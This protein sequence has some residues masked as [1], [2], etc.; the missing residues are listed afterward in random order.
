MS[1]PS[2]A[3]HNQVIAY[4]AIQAKMPRRESFINKASSALIDESIQKKE[5][6]MFLPTYLMETHMQDV[7]YE[8]ALY[9]I[10][11]MGVLTDGRRINVIL[12]DIQPYFEVQ[13]PDDRESQ[14]AAINKIN[15]LLEDEPPVK[16][17]VVNAK[18]FRYYRKTKAK[19]LRLYYTKTKSRCAAIRLVRDNGFTTTT[20]DTAS[21]YRVV[22]R[23][24]LTTFSSWA[25][26]EDYAKVDNS[27][28]LKGTTY[29]VSIQNYKAFTD[30]LTGDLLKDK[31]LSV[32]WD[33]ETWSKDGDV[34][35]P[36]N[37]N[38]N[39]FC[40]SMTFQWVNEN[41]P[42]YKV[43]LCDYPANAKQ[44]YA[45][46]V[47]GKEENIIRGFADIFELMRPE[48]IFGFN[49]SDYDWN[50]LIKRAAQYKGVLSYIATKLDSTIPY[51]PYTDD[52]VFKWSF[53]KEH[54]KVEADTY[55]D[56]FALMVPGYIPVDVRTIF[57]RL[58]PTAEQSSLKWFLAKNKLGGKEDMPY[59]EMFKIYRE[60][61]DF[62]TVHSD[63]TEKVLAGK[64]TDLPTDKW[65]AKELEI[66]N[67]LKKKLMDINYYCVIDAQRCHDLVKIRSVVMDHREVSNLAYC[68]V[69]DAFFRANGM[70]V[71]NLTIAIG[72]GK[73]FGMRFSNIAN[74]GAEEGKYPGAFVLPP[75]KGLKITKLSV[76]ERIKKGE[77]TK[78]MPAPACQEW[79]GTQQE[80]IN[81]YHNI[82]NKYG[83]IGTTELVASV[84]ADLGEKLP[85]KF[86]DFW[87]ETIGRPITGLDFSSLYPSLIRAYNFSPEFCIL[88]KKQAQ[89]VAETGQR[90][91]KVDFDFHGKRKVAYFI[92]HNNKYNP[93]EPGFQFGVYPYILD[94]LFKKRAVLKKAMKKF[95]HRKEEIEAM[96]MEEQNAV[97]AEYEDVVF[98]NNYLN[99]K[100]NAL[101]V[102]MNTFYGEAGNRRSPFFVMEVAGGITS[103]GQKNIKFAYAFVK[104]KGCGV[105]YGDSV[106]SYTPILVKINGEETYCEIK[107]LVNDDAYSDYNNGKEIAIL[108]DV[109]VW[110]DAGWSNIKHII[111]HKTDKQMFRIMTHGAVI[112]VTEDH[113]LLDENAVAIKPGVSLGQK[114]L[115]KELPQFAGNISINKE[116]AWVIGLFV[117]EGSCGSYNCKSGN[118]SSWGLVNQDLNLLNK[119][120]Q[121]LEIA[122][123]A[124]TWKILNCMASSAVHK[125][126]PCSNLVKNK[127]I[128][129]V[130]EWRSMCYYE[131]SKIVPN[132]IFSS[133]KEI[134]LEFF[135]GYYWGD[136]DKSSNNN[137]YNTSFDNISKRFD[138]KSQLSAFSF[139]MLCKNLGF[140]I[141]MHCRTDKLDIYR[142]TIT[143]SRQRKPNN[144]VKK[145]FKL[146]NTLD[147]VY[148][149][150]TDN[151]HF[152]AGV[153]NLV[154]HNTDSLYL[155]TPEQFF[156]ESDKAFYSGRIG[157]LDY[158]TQLVETTFK[159]INPIRD[160]VNKA[161]IA[162]NGT[163]FLSMAYEEVLAPVAFTAK[164]KYFGIAHDSIPNF[165]PKDL[166]IRGLEVKKRGVSELLRKIFMEIM[167][168]SCNPENVY[169]LVELVLMKIDEIYSRKWT[170][171]DFIQTG[172]YRPS[173]KNVKIKTFIDRMKER[174][175]DVKS[176]ERFNY[177]IVKKYPYMYDS[178][179][180]KVELSIGD[181]L[182]LA[183]VFERQ[184]DMEIDLDYYM[185]GS[186][187]G[188]LARLITY[189][190]M[191]K[192]E[193]ADQTDEEVKIAEDRIYKNACKFIESYCSKYYANYNTFGKTHQ[194]IF[195]T[196]SKAIQCVIKDQDS[197][198]GDLLGANVNFD[199]FE[200]WFVEYTEK[201]ANKAVVGYGEGFIIKELQKINMMINARGTTSETET[202]NIKK[203][204]KERRA[205][206]LQMLQKNYYGGAK[207]TLE[208][209][210][211]DYKN[212]MSILRKRLRENHQKFMKAYGKYNHSVDEVKEMMCAKIGGFDELLKPTKTAQDFQLEDFEI[213]SLDI[214]N[215]EI[216]EFANNKADKLLE[217]EQ[218]VSIINELKILHNNMLAAHLRIKRTRDVVS[219]LKLRRDNIVRTIVRPDES[220]IQQM[221][222]ESALDLKKD[223]D[224]LDI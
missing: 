221:L 139:Y 83:A 112:D 150:E 33:I 122:Y 70:K 200:A 26:L 63:E 79:I 177:V 111:R 198:V 9:K 62:M 51:I 25:V 36:D 67:T 176:N 136:G 108:K 15:T 30:E 209:H 24:Y 1:I 21:Y 59:E 212:T 152:S 103:Y 192:V 29:R 56:G 130:E 180:R 149:L 18:P 222:H 90:I 53:K 47:C 78:N 142:L 105:Y 159:E 155:S 57:R 94:D 185:Q 199:D 82:I 167:W 135:K 123:P 190:D 50:W 147:Y 168:T 173:K 2:D 102:F 206:K 74:E 174:G 31:T 151:H 104:E 98:N 69:Y 133:T 120:K 95:V 110:S 181:K 172:V 216:T 55:I 77:L 141:S 84:E 88:D 114:L 144:V 186:I 160:G 211:L 6:L 128:E 87:L 38:D 132:I 92:W 127:I 163:N 61:R 44:G 99:S 60:Y 214:F 201:K 153:G 118:K 208:R 191:F 202:A 157:K 137:T 8:K 64:S 171:Q 54:V 115:T 204:I 43:C 4:N 218:F 217:D 11:L 42:F 107:D 71:R 213:G 81:K 121:I 28:L 220:V 7:K 162:D 22:C 182:E 75:R 19:F 166:F 165:K 41:E 169:D 178:R 12:D 46:I 138:I 14:E 183:D 13:L 106:A 100:Q 97:A 113:S 23:D 193:P 131:D 194:K 96:A 184:S 5:K 161:F 148:D 10:I 40:L 187:N 170:S 65:S 196:A 109:Q 3:V 188:Q 91:T 175:I 145:I 20:D 49:D 195:K 101:K 17:S 189:H 27:T 125:L 215:E 207:S 89:E 85:K 143:Q 154:V 164:K 35:M 32:C 45:T 66:Y 129:I 146:P 116:L 93:D 16:Q 73:Q 210:E 224:D 34:P 119:S 124:Y 80:E 68:S 156:T 39:M 134:Q 140:N 72:Q 58:Y 86:K 117:A 223:V 52:G 158:W 219:Y 203:E 37:R 126:V 179:G 48:F 205:E 76:E 197:L